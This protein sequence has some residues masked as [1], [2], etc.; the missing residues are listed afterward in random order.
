MIGCTCLEDLPKWA[1][2]YNRDIQMT[3]ELVEL[4]IL[5]RL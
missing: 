5:R 2:A 3:E 1:G 4:K